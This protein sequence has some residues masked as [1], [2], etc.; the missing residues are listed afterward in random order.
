M[1]LLE[2][3]IDIILPVFLTP[4]E[5]ATLQVFFKYHLQVLNMSTFGN[6][7]ENY[8]IVRPV[9]HTC[10]HNT[11]DQSHSIGDT[12]AKI[13]GISGEWRHKDYHKDG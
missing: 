2:F 6:T 1:V 5:K 4:I 10:Q 12:V 3:F 9:P 13:L 11:V 8:G 7:A